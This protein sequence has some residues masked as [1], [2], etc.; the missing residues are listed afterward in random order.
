MRVVLLILRASAV[1]GCGWRRTACSSDV[2]R[3][4]KDSAIAGVRREGT[5]GHGEDTAEG[6]PLA[7]PGSRRRGAE[8]LADVPGGSKLVDMANETKTGSTRCRR[9]CAASTSSRSASRSSRSSSAATAKKPAREEAG[10]RPQAG[11][12][13]QEAAGSEASTSDCAGRA[14]RSAPRHDLEPHRRRARLL[15]VELDR[16]R[17]VGVDRDGGAAQQ[18]GLR[19]GQ[20]RAAVGLRQRHEQVALRQVADREHVEEAVVGL[21]VGA[22]H[23]PAAE[24]LARSRRRRRACGRR[25]SRRRR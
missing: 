24:V 12:P 25:G 5:I 11:E 14:A 6:H 1:A 16:Q 19:V 22:D 10:A 23:H 8:Q 7:L 13:P 15:A 2:D 20:V 18:L 9:S 3:G 17:R 4:E 21:G